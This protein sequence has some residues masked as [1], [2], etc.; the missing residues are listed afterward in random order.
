MSSKAE[1]R[2]SAGFDF[3]MLG[4]SVPACPEK[5]FRVHAPQKP[6]RPPDASTLNGVDVSTA[7]ITLATGLIIYGRSHVLSGG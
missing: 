5:D 2:S 6:F 7:G 3:L 4:A 1:Q